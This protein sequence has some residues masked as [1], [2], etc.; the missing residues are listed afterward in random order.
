M[1]VLPLSS[2]RDRAKRGARNPEKHGKVSVAA[3]DSGF[4]RLRP[5]GFGGRP[6]MTFS[7][8]TNPDRSY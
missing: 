4:V 2:F 3:L 8:I 7:Y 6:G 5:A 1:A